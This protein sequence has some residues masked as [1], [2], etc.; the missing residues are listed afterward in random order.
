[1]RHFTE[2]IAR[3][4]NAALAYSKRGVCRIRLGDRAAARADFEAALERDARCVPA[5]VNV[6][7]ME[8]EEGRLEESRVK[9]ERAIE[10]DPDYALAHHN[11][12]VVYRRLGRLVDSVRA[13]RKADMLTLWPKKKSKP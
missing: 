3:G 10:L 9:Y 13:L 1:M 8:L 6:A 7:N 11:L 5:L 2:S 12:G 4:E